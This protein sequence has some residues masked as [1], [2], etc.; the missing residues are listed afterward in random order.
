MIFF[1]KLVQL[2]CSVQAETSTV[3]VV[4]AFKMT[5]LWMCDVMRKTSVIPSKTLGVIALV[6]R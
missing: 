2:L 3:Y 1:R 4:F 6:N 5:T